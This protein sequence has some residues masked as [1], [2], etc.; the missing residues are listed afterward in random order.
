MSNFA[1]KVG[2]LSAPSPLAPPPLPR[3]DAYAICLFDDTLSP[4]LPLII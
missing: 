4:Y 3:S 2:G 1:K